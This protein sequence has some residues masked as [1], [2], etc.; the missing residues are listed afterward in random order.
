[1]NASKNA[2]SSK[3]RTQKKYKPAACNDKMTFQEC[4]MAV[5][6]QVVDESETRQG[7]KIANSPEVVQ[8]IQILEDFLFR[9]KLMC[10]GGTAIN[11]ILPKQAQF[12]DRSVEIPDYDFFSPNALED[13]KELA[14]K[15]YLSGYDEV[16]AKSGMHPGT[17]K[18]YVNFLPVADITYLHPTLFSNLMEDAITV[19]GIKYAPPNYLRM[20]MYLELSRPNGDVSRW[21]KVLKRINL[22]NRYYPLNPNANCNDIAFQRGLDA[23]ENKDK[24]ES[25]Y[26]LTRDSFVD[27]GVVFLGG[28]GTALYSKYMKEDQRHQV[29]NIPDF[30]VLAEDPEKCAMIVRDKLMESGYKRVK[31][32]QHTPL[33]EVIPS[34]IEINVGGDVIALIYKPIACHSYNKLTIGGKEILVATI[35]TMLSFYLAFLY[36]NKA[37]FDKERMLCMAAY[38][39]EV[40][41]KNSLEQKGLLK[42]FSL[43]CYGNQPTM[44]DIRAEKAKKYTELKGLNDK[45]EFEKWFLKYSPAQNNP[46]MRGHRL[47]VNASPIV[48]KTPIK[49]VALT[50]PRTA[51]ANRPKRIYKTHRKRVVG[52]FVAEDASKT[53]R[54]HRKP[55]N[56]KD[57]GIYARRHFYFGR[58]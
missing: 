33:G 26:V 37:Y 41:Q 21:E 30:D 39:F 17:Y 35:D 45:K 8:I 28:Y 14:D 9:K 20:S 27:Q 43:D 2:S 47:V 46:H 34:H 52:Q 25:I 5:L 18:V 58:R 11:N 4:E 50:S 42:R 22:L 55:K 15:Y 48:P 23:E 36:A 3:P 7:A 12:Y 54:R 51:P 29:E 19:A 6:R 16:E 57:A 1:M 38:L 49:T 24:S 32:I 44:E 40:E 13:A 31:L 53:R 10:Y 56:V